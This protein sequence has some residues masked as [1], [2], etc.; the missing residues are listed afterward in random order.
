MYRHRA[1]W[2]QSLF[3]PVSHL[4]SFPKA[5]VCPGPHLCLPA[6]GPEAL[7]ARPS[8]FSRLR[9]QSFEVSENSHTLLQRFSPARPVPLPGTLPRR[10]GDRERVCPLW[11][12][13]ARKAR[14]CVCERGEQAAVSGMP[15]VAPRRHRQSAYRGL[16][17]SGAGSSHPRSEPGSGRPSRSWDQRPRSQ[18]PPPSAPVSTSCPVCVLQLN[19]NMLPK[20]GSQTAW[21]FPEEMPLPSRPCPLMLGTRVSQPLTRAL[22]KH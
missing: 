12:G 7:V 2:C 4:S 13:R 14:G 3:G 22:R 6:T 15:V 1:G 11:G 8:R 20:C 5:R 21:V 17:R 10:R 9:I 16:G 19:C 18:Q